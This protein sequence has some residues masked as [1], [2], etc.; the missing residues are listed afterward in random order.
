M[1][2]NSKTENAKQL[3]LLFCLDIKTYHCKTKKMLSFKNVIQIQLYVQIHISSST[4]SPMNE[5][6]PKCLYYCKFTF[7][8]LYS[9]QRRNLA[10]NVC[11]MNKFIFFFLSQCD[12]GS[13]SK[14]LVAINRTLR[15]CAIVL[16]LIVFCA[17]SRH[18]Y[19]S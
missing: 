11:T 8:F 7:L 4:L 13:L 5:P 2:P 17:F 18:V 10:Q 12:K 3:P 16:Y 14:M 1:H 15:K 19:N 6:S 9:I